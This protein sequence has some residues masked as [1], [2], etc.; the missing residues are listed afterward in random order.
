MAAISTEPDSTI[1]SVEDA[2]KASE[3]FL[4][5]VLRKGK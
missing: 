3:N 5:P 1:L 2:L 4:A